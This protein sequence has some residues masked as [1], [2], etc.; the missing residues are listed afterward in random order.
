MLL[1]YMVCNG[2]DIAVQMYRLHWQCNNM[3]VFILNIYLN[4]F[5]FPN[6]SLSKWMSKM[7]DASDCY[8]YHYY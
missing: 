2:I 1:P 3:L 8:Y 5:R 4:V 7:V 6:V